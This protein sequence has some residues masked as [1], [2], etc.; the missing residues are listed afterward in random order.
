MPDG[1]SFPSTEGASK[2]LGGRPSWVPTAEQ[3]RLVEVLRAGG[4]SL[5]LIARAIGVS[6]PTL[7]KCCGAELRYAHADLEAR[8]GAALVR[9]ALQGHVGAIRFWL[10]TRGKD[11]CWRAARYADVADASEETSDVISEERVILVPLEELRA[12]REMMDAARKAAKGE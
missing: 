2:N 12:M 4:N 1:V 8:M 3:R 9:A 11:P 5:P 6:V 10:T 7:R